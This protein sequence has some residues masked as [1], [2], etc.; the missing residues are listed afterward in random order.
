MQFVG[1]PDVRPCLFADL[2]NRRRIELPN[3]LQNGFGQNPTHL[4]RTGSPLFQRRIVEIGVRVRVENFMRELRWHGRIHGHAADT[5]VIDSAQQIFQSVNI[6]RLGQHVFHYL[7]H[8][9]VVGN[10]NI[11]HDI[12][13]ASGHIGEH[14][15]QQIVR[16]HALNLRG[17]FLATLKTQQRQRA[18]GVPAPASAEDGRSQRSLFQNRLHCLRTQKM[19]NVS[20]RKTVLLGQRDVQA[21]VRSRSLQLEIKAAAESFAQSQTPGFVDSASERRVDYELHPAAFIEKAF[22]DNCVLCRHRAE[23]SPPLQNVFDHLL[24]ARIVQ[25][26]FFFQPRNRLSDFW[27]AGRNP[28]WRSVQQPVADLLPQIGNVQRQLF[29]SRRSFA[30]PERDA[31]R[32]AVS[33][34][35]QHASRF[36]FHPANSP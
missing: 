33:V 9:R 1:I 31:G 18:I 21:V 8:Q 27:L 25:A 28:D 32:R 12:F 5:A 11:S 34:F 20:Q 35:H 36:A 17:N 14:R 2:C 16:P 22:C 3:F 7:I 29:G 23:H 4:H 30:P 26:T 15:G 13:L 24:G 19:K 6:H 10:L